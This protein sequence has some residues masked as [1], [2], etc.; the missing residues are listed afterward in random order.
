METLATPIQV[1]DLRE[2]IPGYV[3]Q[4]RLGAGGFGEVWKAAAPGGLLKAVKIVFGQMN[5]DRAARELRALE[6][7][8]QVRHPMLLS[9][10]RIELVQGHLVIVTEL[11][12]GCLRD[13]C[14]ANGASDLATIPREDLLAYLR[15]AADALDYL[16]EQHGLQH[17]DVKPENLLLVANRVKVADFGLLRDLRDTGESLI[18]G[19]TP[20]YAGPEVF[21]GRPHRQSDQYGLA[22]LYQEL[23][24]GEAPFGG[25]TVAQLASQHLHSQPHLAPL[26]AFDQPIIARALSKSPER[27]FPNCRALVDELAA[28]PVSAAHSRLRR[29]AGGRTDGSS[30]W[31]QH[32]SSDT[33]AAPSRVATH[34]LATNYPVPRRIVDLAPLDVQ[35]VAPLYRPTV[36]IGLGG[37]AVRILTHLRRRLRA[38]FGRIDDAPSLRFLAID[39]DPKAFSPTLL[40]AHQDQLRLHESLLLPLTEGHEYRARSRALLEWL[41][42]RWLYNMPRSRRTEGL[43]PLGRLALIDHFPAVLDA[44]HQAV[45]SAESPA[46]VEATS[47]RLGLEFQRGAPRIMVLS[48]IAGGSGGG[49]VCD[50]AYTLRELLAQRGLSDEHLLGVL[51]FT[52]PQR[53]AARDLAIASSV[54]CLNELAHFTA[55]GYPGEPSCGLSASGPGGPF[56]STY[57]V[58]LGEAPDEPA[59]DAAIGEVADYLYETTVTPAVAF[60]DLCRAAERRP[61]ATTENGTSTDPAVRSFRLCRFPGGTRRITRPTTEDLVLS[62]LLAQWSQSARRQAAQPVRAGEAGGSIALAAQRFAKWSAEIAQR[63]PDERIAAAGAGGTS[64]AAAAAGDQLSKLMSEVESQLRRSLLR[65]APARQTSGCDPLLDVLTPLDA[66]TLLPTLRKVVRG[67]LGGRSEPSTTISPGARAALAASPG[68]SDVGGVGDD[69]ATEEAGQ[70]FDQLGQSAPSGLDCG[71]ARRLLVRLPAAGS[72][73]AAEAYT[74]QRIAQQPITFLPADDDQRT[75]CVE[76]ERIALPA[77]V[78]A[79]IRNRSDYLDI[80]QRLHTRVDVEWKPPA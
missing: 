54:A 12:D 28:A 2:P 38:R 52:A 33:A 13:R 18:A 63:R 78:A 60:F 31:N 39:T 56:S 71:G 42:R 23:L 51:T 76:L 7:I 48:S 27:R 69:S 53:A 55:E 49:M 6:R 44:L 34:R 29:T 75:I 3:L 1:F 4:E 50:V 68:V 45:A 37:E 74:D 22:V 73:T 62:G 77:V 40:D 10:E 36:F 67:V 19:L 17:L 11:A 15:D 9:L 72:L 41:H 80:A 21:D 57:L 64:L 70:L 58:H 65:L 8:K 32:R 14:H 16:V 79:L 47:Q 35:G 59:Y 25:R 20:L 5:A 61:G 30:A 66:E 24:T 46:S 26:P 43:R